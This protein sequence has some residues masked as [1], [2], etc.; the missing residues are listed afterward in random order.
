MFRFLLSALCLAVVA[1][2]CLKSED[3]RACP[4]TPSSITAPGTEQAALATYLDTNGIV[5]IKHPAGF[6][7]QVLTPGTGTD[8]IGL[9]SQIQVTYT[10][11]FINDTIFDKQ[12]GVVFILG[13][14]IEGWKKSIPMLQ[15]GGEMK[16]YIPPSLGYGSEDI[17]NR[18]GEVVIPKNSI[19]K[20]DLKL[21][22]YTKAN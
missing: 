20:F 14:L 18:D 21:V 9:C 16:L 2:S 17:K 1:A 10:G 6:Y 3:N 15:R 22:D 12:T 5:A 11:R 13:E 4:Y 8:S 19:L 7:Y